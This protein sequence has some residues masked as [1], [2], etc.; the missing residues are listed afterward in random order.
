MAQRPIAIIG[1]AG[2]FPRAPGIEA[3]WQALLEARACVGPVPPQRWD[4]RCVAGDAPGQAGRTYCPTAGMDA[5]GD[6]YD[7]DFFGLDDSE[8]RSL[9]PQQGCMLELAWHACEDAGIPPASLAGR[10]VGVY[11]GV[12]TRDFDRRM[13]ALFE[14]INLQT[15]T[16]ASGAVIA[17][18]LS[19]VFGLTGPSVAI[20][21]ACASSLA[22]IHLACRA[23]EDDE[24]E[25]ALA[26][27]VQLMLSPANGIAFAQAGM[28]S[29]DGRCKP[30]AADA[31]GF[32]CGEGA[33][34]LLLKPLD[35][36]RRDGDRLRAVIRGSAINHNGRSNG[37]SAPYRAAQ[38][39][40]M[41]AALERAGVA[42]ASIAY[43]EAHAPG[44]LLGD[45]I[46]FQAIR[47][48]YGPGRTEDEPCHVGSVKSNIG[49]LEAAAG[50]A[51]L[52]KAALAVERGVLP[53]SLHCHPPSPL[54]KLDSDAMR[55]CARTQAWPAGDAPR[56]AG[57]SAFSFG[58][59]NAH[60][61]LEQAPLVAHE[62]PVAPDAT[63]WLL[64]A[65]ARSEPALHALC[66]AY[67]EHLQSLQEAGAGRALLR[68]F[69]SST[70]AHRQ[71]HAHRHALL[72]CG[73][74][75]AIDG[76]QAIAPGGPGTR[77]LRLGLAPGVMSDSALPVGFPVGWQG[78]AKPAPAEATANE[79]AAP[80]LSL[81]TALLALLGMRRVDTGELAGSA[82]LSEMMRACR[83]AGLIASKGL[84]AGAADCLVFA[85]TD[86]DTSAAAPADIAWR[87]AV[88]HAGYAGQC[89][90]LVAA[91]YRQGFSLR[92]NAFAA[93]DGFRR[94]ELPLYP[95]QRRRHHVIPDHL[96]ATLA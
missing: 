67:R 82:L 83:Y 87:P 70:L 36:A 75:D 76:L 59:A 53:A 43:V 32:V 16:G 10:E 1:M 52:I 40:V 50:V 25:L 20:D 33:G 78:L 15:S 42:P 26:G 54:L 44:T 45:A 34:V 31:D 2:R 28:L 56:R 14:H 63:P 91:L 62:P 48:T 72:C 3:F 79:P 84:P 68:D 38:S 57:V 17:N 60:L 51:A 61:I 71:H 22:S 19:Y 88:D 85:D 96:L 92:W 65:S 30:F 23:L 29:R 18:R 66:E 49:H 24:C 77:R 47:E 5:D 58:G 73:W 41:R 37:L 89:A 69:C 8:A 4:A 11:L 55:V 80:A 74:Q 64:F 13:S 35:L 46:E 93:L 86:A 27:G 39:K 21:A 7:A 90:G 95:F 81:L 12:S 9:D 6:C 94:A